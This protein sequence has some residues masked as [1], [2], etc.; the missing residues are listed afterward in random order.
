MKRK[1]LVSALAMLFGAAI[2]LATEKTQS[3]DEANLQLTQCALKVSGMTCGGCASSAEAR[4]TKIP[5]VKSAR[6]DFDSAEARVEYDPK[7]TTAEKIV[8][9]FN[10][11]GGF[12]AELS[13]GKSR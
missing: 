7:V 2:G 3:S 13:K 1:L 6:V 5:G 4:L 8:A 10:E 11:S 12:R 9:A